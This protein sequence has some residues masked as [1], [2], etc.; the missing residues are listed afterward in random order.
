MEDSSKTIDVYDI[1][2]NKNKENMKKHVY[3]R[4][5]SFCNF[6]QS[7]CRPST[8]SNI[9]YSE[10]TGPINVGTK[11]CLNVYLSLTNMVAMPIL[12]W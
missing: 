12:I 2:V 9:F 10:T 7:I 3:R 6:A 4:N 11:L 8:F 1:N 5:R